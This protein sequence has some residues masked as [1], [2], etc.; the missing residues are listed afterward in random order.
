MSA[1]VRCAFQKAGLCRVGRRAHRDPQTRDNRGMKADPGNRSPK[2]RR[3]FWNEGPSD[4]PAFTRAVPFTLNEG[5][6]YLSVYGNPDRA[7]RQGSSPGF[8]NHRLL[9][10]LSPPRNTLVGPVTI[11]TVNAVQS[12]GLGETL[13]RRRLD[14]SLRSLLVKSSMSVGSAKKTCEPTMQLDRLRKRLRAVAFGV[15]LLLVPGQGE[16][17]TR[18]GRYWGQDSA[19]P[20]RTTHTGQVRGSLVHVK[21]TDVG[22]HTFLGIPFAKPPLGLLRF[23]PPEPPE[24]WSGIKDGTSHP[25][26]C[27]QDFASVKRMT[28][29]LLNVTLPST[30]MSEDCLYL[31]IYT[32][33]HSHEGSKLP[34]M[35][36]IHGGGFVMGMASTYDGSAL[37]AFEDVV[38][39]VIQYRLG[40]LGFFSTGD[41]HATGNWGYLDQV[42][43]LRWVQQNI[44]YFGG[45]PD[46][47]T[48][49]GTS[50]GGMSVSLHVV[51]PMSK[52]LFHCAIMESGVALLPNFTANSSDVVST[53]VAN[54]SACGQV[55]SEALVDCLR[56]KSEEEILAI[57][58]PFSIIPGLVDGIFLP[59]H[60]QELLASADLHP[61][62]S[63]IGVN[64]DEYSWILPS[65]MNNS[66]AQKEM[67]RETI[68]DDLQKISK[69][70][71]MP[72]EFGDL[73]M[74]EYIGDSEDPQTLRIQFHEILGDCIFVIPAL[75]VAKLQCSYAPVY[76]YE[77]QHQPSFFRDFRPSYVR[78]DH[79][80][81]VH[82]IF[83][84]PFGSSHMQ[85]TEE[86]ELLSRKM[87]KYWANFARNGNPNG[88]G[89]PHWPVFNQEEQYMQ[90]NTQPAVGRALKAHRLQFWTKIL[91]QKIRELMEAKEKH[92]ELYPN[93]SEPISS[94]VN[95]DDTSHP[96]ELFKK[97][98]GCCI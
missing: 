52:G 8:P 36:W 78:A 27:L 46:H 15:L 39:V 94:P 38:V 57:S 56:H 34:V 72:P 83:R 62:P 47:V 93:P 24:S 51:S 76:F 91:P 14:A 55:D 74:E 31:N 23:A 9:L 17:P 61:V 85:L 95:G 13:N 32:P 1:T 66:D 58:K 92:T 97:V 44:I 5:R 22:I 67:D 73:L 25:A 87:M 29:K 50:A 69:M 53:V 71:M 82:F 7:P 40:L 75:Q 26:K 60:P 84:S 49:F 98:T 21:N 77:F 45:D 48:I 41:K 80:D 90:L 3:S 16:A 54:L 43:A 79:G 28:L 70:M 10:P 88:E 11:R 68:K 89:L 20:V 2:A 4:F 64:S 6:F 12:P 42:A 35:V 19:S 81:E 65:F 59:K 96:C 63:I 86:E 33:A 30:S 18:G 37:A